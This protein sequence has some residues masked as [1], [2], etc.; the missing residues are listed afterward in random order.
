MRGFLIVRLQ[1]YIQNK[2]GKN[3]WTMIL[4]SIKIPTTKLY[5]SQT[6]Y[7]DEE[8]YRII[9]EAI[10]LTGFTANQFFEDFGYSLGPVFLNTLKP[11]IKPTWKAIDVLEHI[12][13]FNFH[14]LQQGEDPLNMGKFTAKRTGPDSIQLEYSSPRQ[15]CHLAVGLFKAIANLMDEELTI[16]QSSCMLHNSDKCLFEI[17]AGPLKKEKS[18]QFPKLN[19][20]FS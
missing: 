10:K 20:S 11:M 3:S 14:M 8:F 16:T 2:Y 4:Q 13:E 15:L 9:T 17:T 5:F 1:E 19:K 12:Q 6:N 7:A 18:A